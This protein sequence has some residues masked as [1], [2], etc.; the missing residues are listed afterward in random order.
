MESK[1]AESLIRNG[2]LRLTSV[3]EYR[4][5]NRCNPLQ[6]DP[7]EDIGIKINK[8]VKCTTDSANPTYIWCCSHDCADN[9]QILE[10]DTKYDCVVLINDPRSF[11]NLIREH[12]VNRNTPFRMQA[13]PVSYDKEKDVDKKYFWGEN[14]FQKHEKYSHQQEFRFAAT[15][16]SLTPKHSLFIDLKLGDCSSYAS[17]V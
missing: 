3:L 1:W 15:D 8:G 5:P 12:L 13:G 10:T 2:D 16:S 6:R 4:K 17:I 7:Y 9:Q 14:S 11:F